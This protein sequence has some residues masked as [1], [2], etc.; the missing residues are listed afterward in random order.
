M[1]LHDPPHPPDGTLSA[2]QIETL[3]AAAAAGERAALERLLEHFLPDL[4]AFVRLRAGPAVRARESASD[5]VQSVCRQVLEQARSFQHQNEAAF[6]RWLFTTA[7]RKI[8]DRA[9]YHAAERR[10]AGREV[11]LASGVEPAGDARL[12]SSYR[13]F[14]TPTR[15]FGLKEEL[16]RVEAA[17]DELGEEDRTL[18][19]EAHLLGTSRAELARR[20]GKSEG[21]VRVQLHRALARLAVRLGD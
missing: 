7:V 4:R 2:E 17:F 11:H 1:D 10:D 12:L 5:L 8:A 9:Q 20:L 15:A 6:R 16:E 14:A 18:V 19:L 13:G 21:A 3:T